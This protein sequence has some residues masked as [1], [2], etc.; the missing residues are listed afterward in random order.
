MRPVTENQIITTKQVLD[1]EACAMC[2][3]STEEGRPHA[4]PG[5]IRAS[6]MNQ[7]TRDVG[8]EEG[9]GVNWVEASVSQ[10]NSRKPVLT[11]TAA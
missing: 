9:T 10:R 11:S 8:F 2:Q 4:V 7:A 3:E 6:F 5:I 1:L